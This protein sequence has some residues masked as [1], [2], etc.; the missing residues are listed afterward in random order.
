MVQETLLSTHGVCSDSLSARLDTLQKGPGGIRP[1]LPPTLKQALFLAAIQQ[2]LLPP[3]PT[4]SL[5]ALRALGGLVGGKVRQRREQRS[6][7]SPA[8]LSAGLPGVPW[9]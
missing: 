1:T 2:P 5:E 6:R 3:H 4:K 7:G 8:R 9:P